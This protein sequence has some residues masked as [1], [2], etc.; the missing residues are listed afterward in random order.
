MYSRY[1]S[2][3]FDITSFLENPPNN[4][5]RH[6]YNRATN[7]GVIAVDRVETPQH[8]TVGTIGI[9]RIL[10]ISQNNRIK[11]HA[12][13]A[14]IHHHKRFDLRQGY[15]QLWLPL[16]A[17]E[18]RHSY[19]GDQIATTDEQFLE[20]GWVKVQP[21]LARYLPIN[22]SEFKLFEEAK[23]MLIAI[24]ALTL[25][26]NDPDYTAVPFGSG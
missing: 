2:L 17:V 3:Q 16:E 19:R 23:E 6:K 11:A 10:G 9:P 18:S 5:Q 4:T 15:T 25:T 1:E 21:L 14:F 26:R 24:G 20:D 22:K 7:L 8:I 12:L 13:T